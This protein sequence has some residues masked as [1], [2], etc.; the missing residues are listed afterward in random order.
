MEPAVTEGRRPLAE[1]AAECDD[2]L[3]LAAGSALSVTRY[4]IGICVW[5]V[6]LTVEIDPQRPLGLIQN[7]ESNELARVFAA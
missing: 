1:I 2:R 7:G 6:D 3:G 4:L 5:P